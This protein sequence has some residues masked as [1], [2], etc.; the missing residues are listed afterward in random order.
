[1][2]VLSNR[3][4]GPITPDAERWTPVWTGARPSDHNET[5]VLY[6]AQARPR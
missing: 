2:L 1:M 4:S 6:R 5:F 3:S